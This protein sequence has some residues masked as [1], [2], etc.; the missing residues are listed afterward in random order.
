M[1]VRTRRF[2]TAEHTTISGIA[3]RLEP[4][5]THGYQALALQPGIRHPR[6][7]GQG[8]RQ[9]P[10]TLGAQRRQNRLAFARAQGIVNLLDVNMRIW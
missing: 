1:R 9:V 10:V 4:Q 7:G 2:T 8:L 3:M 5:V 6:L